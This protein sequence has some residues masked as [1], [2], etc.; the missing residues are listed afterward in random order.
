MNEKNTID[1]LAS[2][3]SCIED[4]ISMGYL[5]SSRIYGDPMKNRQANLIFNLAHIY[6]INVEIERLC[7]MVVKK[8]KKKKKSKTMEA[9]VLES[10]IR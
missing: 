10:S 4:F 2:N 7:E 8:K 9:N 1:K 6:S 3:Y 5:N